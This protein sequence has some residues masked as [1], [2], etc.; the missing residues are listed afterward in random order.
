MNE[1]T[2]AVG[3]DFKDRKTGLIVFGVLEILLGAFFA[4]VVLAMTLGL[5]AS[6]VLHKDSS[7]SINAGMMIPGLLFYVLLATWFIWMGIG[8]LMARRWARAL[9]LVTSWFWFISGILGL[10]FMLTLMPDMYGPLNSAQIPRTVAIIVK[11]AT[12]GIMV[13]FYIIIPGAIILFYGSRHVKATC[14]Q[15]DPQVRWTDRCPLPVL[16]VSLMAGCSAACVPLT[17]LYNWVIPFFGVI[18]SGPAGAAVLI[19]GV[20]L[21][22]YVARGMYRLQINAWRGAVGLVVFWGVSSGL[23]FTRTGLMELYEKM[24]FPAQQMDAIRQMPLTQGHW[25]ALFSVLWI[26]IALG[27]LLYIKRYFTP[28]VDPKGTP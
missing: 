7:Q 19:P 10:A 25:V 4:L 17:G 16:A 18:L 13:V 6:A 15:R 12:I 20:L 21:L 9:L 27:Y 2:T 14:E 22:A 5:V 24:N 26:V 11:W 1:V 8:S 28:P 23:T 3:P